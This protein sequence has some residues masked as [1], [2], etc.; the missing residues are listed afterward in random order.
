MNISDDVEIYKLS[1]V[2]QLLNG[3]ESGDFLYE[4]WTKSNKLRYLPKFIG[5]DKDNVASNEVQYIIAL[6]DIFEKLI[7]ILR[8]LIVERYCSQTSE[9]LDMDYTTLQQCDD[10]IT[11]LENFQNI[12]LDSSWSAMYEKVNISATNI[13][14]KIDHLLSV[15]ETGKKFHFI[16]NVKVE[17][18]ISSEHINYKSATGKYFIVDNYKE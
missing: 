10:L 9:D 1:K 16:T 11:E 5:R 6:E 15:Y 18:F 12:S 2:L 17:D 3:Q 7:S 14:V 8:E 13:C 4:Y